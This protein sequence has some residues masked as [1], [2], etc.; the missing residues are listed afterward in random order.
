MHRLLEAVRLA[1]K[2][3]VR[4]RN[5]AETQRGH[6][7]LGLRFRDDRILRALEEDRGCLDMACA[8]QRRALA[9]ERLLGG[10]FAN[11]RVVVSRLELVGL[12]RQA[13]KLANS[14]V[15]G[16]GCED[17]TESQATQCGIAPGA[18]ALYDQAAFV[19][20]AL[21]DE[22][23]GSRNGIRYVDD[24]PLT[25]QPLAIGPAEPGAPA[26]VEVGDG[27]SAAGP[28]LNGER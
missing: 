11:Q 4:H 21:G 24:S 26:I 1:L 5:A 17:I 16:T 23:P 15:G 20:L 22:M 8:A 13:R 9:E 18:A 3:V 6:H 7:R 28:K 12:F 27:E 14:V 25:V 10:P 19:G 2:Q